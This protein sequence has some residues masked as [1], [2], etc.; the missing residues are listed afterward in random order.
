MQ[1]VPA[2]DSSDVPT[3]RELFEEYAAGM[4]INFCFQGFAEELADLPGKYAPPDGRLLLAGVDTRVAACVAMRRLA[5]GICEMK[6]LYVR[7]AFR[8][9]GVGRALCLA[10]IQA[11]REAGYLAMRLD[12]RASMTPAVTLYESLGFRRIAAYYDN[13]LP[14]VRYFEL[15]IQ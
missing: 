2:H 15:P 13:P 12:T 4:G 9:H 11:A 10:A 5:E 6:R 14:D 7:P 8:R 1:I 3:V